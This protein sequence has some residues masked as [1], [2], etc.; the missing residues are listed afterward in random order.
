MS[1]YDEQFAKNYSKVI[2]LALRRLPF[3]EVYGL[4]INQQISEEIIKIYELGLKKH[5]DFQMLTT[6]EEWKK[7]WNKNSTGLSSKE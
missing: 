4:P 2:L 6:K 5:N 3:N 1:K 7:A